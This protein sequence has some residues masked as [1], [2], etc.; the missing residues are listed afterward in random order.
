MESCIFCEI[1]GN[2]I[3]ASV[4]SKDEKVTVLMDIQPINPGHLLIIPNEHTAH[5]TEL[6]EEVGAHL[7]RTG[8][9]V[10]KALRKSGV[11]CEGVNLLL[12]DGEAAGQEVFHVHLHVFPRFKGDGFGF[13]FGPE[14]NSKPS[15][16]SLDA[17]AEKIKASLSG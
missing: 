13:R 11:R 14:Y 15:R 10:G 3:A 4:V 2:R 8:M 9:Q 7:F 12:A 5:L 6:D 16:A 1:I 17:V